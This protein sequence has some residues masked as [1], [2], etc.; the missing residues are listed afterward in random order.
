MKHGNSIILLF[1]LLL[2][3]ATT[4]LAQP[5]TAK[6]ASGSISEIG[7]WPFAFLNISDGGKRNDV[8]KEIFK[9]KWG[10]LVPLDSAEEADFT[11]AFIFQPK[12]DSK[13]KTQSIKF[14]SSNLE[15]LDPGWIS[16]D[17]RG[18]MIA[19]RQTSEGQLRIVWLDANGSN[20][21]AKA[22]KDLLKAL[23]VNK[24]TAMQ[25]NVTKSPASSD[26]LP[27]K[28][29]ASL[30][31]TILYKERAKYT[32][33]ARQDKVQGTVILSAVYGVNGRISDIRVVRGL[34]QG[35]TVTAIEAVKK[36]RFRPAMRDGQPVSVRGNVEF[37]FSLY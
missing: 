12:S 15:S 2:L 36:I 4:A 9:D 30:K 13:T 22:I 11:V 25:L 1:S 14:T 23:S 29:T 28:M 5:P 17:H 24:Q 8:V 19:F 7:H 16:S 34:P 18:Q 21:P 37:N 10:Q 33:D 3:N 27:E 26:G 20:R 32:E 6:I 31:P 35:L